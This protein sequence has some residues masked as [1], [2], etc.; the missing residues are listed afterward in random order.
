[1]VASK[2]GKDKPRSQLKI[3]EVHYAVLSTFV[4]AFKKFHN[5]SIYF[6]KISRNR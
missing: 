1:M 6:L 2:I 4:H 5:R 3:C